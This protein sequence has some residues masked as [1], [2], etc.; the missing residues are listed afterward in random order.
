MPVEHGAGELV[1]AFELV[2]LFEYPLTQVLVVHIAEQELG[3]HG[4]SQLAQH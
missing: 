2:Q 1:G 3:A 4:P